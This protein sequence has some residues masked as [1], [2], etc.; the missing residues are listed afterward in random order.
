[1][2]MALTLLRIEKGRNEKVLLCQ[3]I[4]SRKLLVNSMKSAKTD[5]Q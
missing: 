3:R 1:M 2:P 4:L 5:G